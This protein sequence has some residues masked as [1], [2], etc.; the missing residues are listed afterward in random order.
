MGA[1]GRE[2]LGEHCGTG[3]KAPSILFGEESSCGEG[4]GPGQN[5]ELVR[6]R[7]GPEGG[8]RAVGPEQWD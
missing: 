1:G 7:K 8:V 6:P 3:E 4:K 5:G 2:A